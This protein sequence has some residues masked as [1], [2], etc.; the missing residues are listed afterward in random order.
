MDDEVWRLIRAYFDRLLLIERYNED[1]NEEIT[2]MLEAGA[3]H[4]PNGGADLRPSLL[5]QSERSGDIFGRSKWR[6]VLM[7]ALALHA[8]IGMGG[9]ALLTV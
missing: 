3:T 8:D 1:A 9:L 6:A 7:R 4:R 5:M 2:E